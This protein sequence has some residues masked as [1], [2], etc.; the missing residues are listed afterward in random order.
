MK[1]EK[2]EKEK[3]PFLF[4]L[5]VFLVVFLAA[6]SAL[7]VVSLTPIDKQLGCDKLINE[8]YFNGARDGHMAGSIETSN[9]TLATGLLPIF[10]IDSTSYEI[11][12]LNLTKFY[13]G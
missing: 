2:I 1:N 7:L 12:Y 5:L 6:T 8:S 13:G 9:F 3:K 10:K 11:Q 4:L